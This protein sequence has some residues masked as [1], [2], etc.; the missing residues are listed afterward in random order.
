VV[1]DQHSI[2]RRR[3]RPRLQ[4]SCH[5][6]REPWASCAISALERQQRPRRHSTSASRCLS[7][8]VR[9]AASSTPNRPLRRSTPHPPSSHS[10]SLMVVRH[11]SAPAATP[12]FAFINGRIRHDFL[13]VAPNSLFHGKGCPSRLKLVSPTWSVRLSSH[14]AK[15]RRRNC[16]ASSAICSPKRLLLSLDLRLLARTMEKKPWS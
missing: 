14:L 8:P 5:A 1:V 3:R 16:Q 7:C 12:A 6:C 4:A 2:R 9:V 13:A 10:P 11:L 15:G